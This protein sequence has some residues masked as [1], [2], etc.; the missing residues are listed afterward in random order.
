[1]AI[2]AMAESSLICLKKRMV[3]FHFAMFTRGYSNP[4]IDAESITGGLEHEFYFPLFCWDD[5]PI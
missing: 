3:I 2:E 4:K 1:M 5:D